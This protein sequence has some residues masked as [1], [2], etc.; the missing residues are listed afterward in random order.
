MFGYVDS[1]AVGPQKELYLD[2]LKVTEYNDS[3]QSDPF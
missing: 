2:Y 1:S 3:S